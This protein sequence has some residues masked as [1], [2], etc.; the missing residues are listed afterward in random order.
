MVNKFRRDYHQTIRVIVFCVALM[1]LLAVPGAAQPRCTGDCDGDGEVSRQEFEYVLTG[2]LGAVFDPPLS[3]DRFECLDP[4]GD[5]TVLPSEVLAW[6]NNAEGP[7]PTPCVGDCNGDGRVAVAELIA[8]VDAV[9][10]GTNDA[11][12]NFVVPCPP[13]ALCIDISALQVA[14]NN[15]LHGCP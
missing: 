3:S 15:A 8:G 5:G 2:V 7:C 12:P 1:V 13:G 11:C 9:L 6:F 14:I 10:N 4:D